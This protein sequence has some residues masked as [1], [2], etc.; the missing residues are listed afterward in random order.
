M[1]GILEWRGN[2]CAERGETIDFGN[3]LLKATGGAEQYDVSA[4]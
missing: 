2:A 4:L 1:K 3:R